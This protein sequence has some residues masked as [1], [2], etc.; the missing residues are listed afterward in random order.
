MALNLDAWSEQEHPLSRGRGVR[1]SGT[2]VRCAEGAKGR[3]WG[4]PL[5]EHMFVLSDTVYTEKRS[6]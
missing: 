6:F 4:K 2:K 3:G 1:E 5:W